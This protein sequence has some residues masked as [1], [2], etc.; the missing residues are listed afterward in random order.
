VKKYKSKFNKIYESILGQASYK[1]AVL[2]DV[3]IAD[4]YIK[5]TKRGNTF[6][7][8]TGKGGNI[9]KVKFKTI[10]T[11]KSEDAASEYFYKARRKIF[12]KLGK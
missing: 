9:L 7:V 11:S 12:N 8:K 4:N 10:Y 3:Q 2:K 5:L 6:N 1:D